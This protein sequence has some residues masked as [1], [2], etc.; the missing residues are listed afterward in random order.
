MLEMILNTWEWIRQ[1]WHSHPL[2][3]AIELLAWLLSIA[4]SF[5]MAITVPDPPLLML[6]P[7]WISGCVL[8]AWAAWSR[9]SF[10]ML[11]NYLLLVTFDSMGLIRILHG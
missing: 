10:G 8:Y 2:R 1:D 4:C 9:R 6:Y 11:A 7:L 3:F 5:I